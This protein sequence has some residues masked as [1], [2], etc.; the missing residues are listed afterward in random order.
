[1]AQRAK[2]HR[3]KATPQ[4]VHTGFFNAAIPPVL[5]IDSG[6]TVVF[7]SMMLMDGQLRCGMTLEELLAKR[8]TYI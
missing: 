8:Q 6:D 3:L 1:M 2:T 7:D 5:T 4:T